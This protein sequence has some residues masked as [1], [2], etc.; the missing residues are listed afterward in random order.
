MSTNWHKTPS[1][2]CIDLDPWNSSVN[3][4]VCR[5]GSAI[6]IWHHDVVLNTAQSVTAAYP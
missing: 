2:K 4:A 5:Q 1:E 3:H 6:A